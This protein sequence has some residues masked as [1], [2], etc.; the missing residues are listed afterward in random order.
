MVDPEGAGTNPL[1]PYVLGCISEKRVRLVVLNLIEIPNL[2]DGL[3]E[4]P[5]T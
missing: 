2:I 5:Q 3:I 1:P 4:N